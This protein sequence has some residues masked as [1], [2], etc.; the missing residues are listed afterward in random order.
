MPLP[1]R[2]RVSTGRVARWVAALAVAA[3]V[4]AGCAGGDTVATE[5]NSGQ[6]YVSGSGEGKVIEPGEREPA[7]D[8]GGTTVDGERLRLADYRGK[9]VVVNF[10]ASWCA[11]CRDEAPA[12]H[13]VYEKTR[14]RGVEFLGIN[15][16]DGREAA[17]AFERNHD[18]PYPSLYDQP[19]EVAL[20]FRETVPPQA[21]PSTIVIDRQGRVAARIIGK[22]TYSQLLPLVNRIAGEGS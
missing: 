5:E 12:L 1:S 11:P 4:F 6:R 17:K 7:P 16:K 8:V 2:L 18:V 14:E 9:V 13:G 21:I 19:G 15:M 3:V 20:A 10:W 22:T